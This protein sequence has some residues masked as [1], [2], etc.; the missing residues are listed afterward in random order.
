M[1]RLNWEL[2]DARD[3]IGAR[4]LARLTPT[5]ARRASTRARTLGRGRNIGEEICD[6]GP[7]GLWFRP[8]GH[9]RFGTTRAALLS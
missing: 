3:L 4:H 8:L 5:G 2:V 1:A 7:Y 9:V 6:E